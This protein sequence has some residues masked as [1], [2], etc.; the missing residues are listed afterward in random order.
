M[1]KKWLLTKL[2]IPGG[3]CG[4]IAVGKP[5]L[6]R[7][8]ILIVQKAGALGLLLERVAKPVDG[9]LLLIALIEPGWLGLG[10]SRAIIEQQ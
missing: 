6:L 4:L 2:I 3:L 5:C 1:L 9:R 8:C 10:G 7:L